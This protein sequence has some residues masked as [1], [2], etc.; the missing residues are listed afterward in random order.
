MA[1]TWPAGVLGAIEQRR[2]GRRDGE[3][4][5][6]AGALEGVGGL[7]DEGPGDDAADHQRRGQLERRLADL[8]EPLEA[9]MRLRCAAI[10][11]TESIEV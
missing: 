8:V 2:L 3:V 9:E 10:W 5:A 4:A 1:K 11:N 6:I 7:A